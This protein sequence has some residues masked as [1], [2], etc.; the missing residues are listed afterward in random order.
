MNTIYPFEPYRD[1]GPRYA[2]TRVFS[3]YI[4]M[5]DGVRIA[6]DVYLPAGIPSGERIPTIL[7]QTR[8]WRSISLRAPFRW[9]SSGEGDS[10]AVTRKGK[11]FF[12]RRGYALVIADVRGTGASFGVS[13]HP[14]EAVTVQ[15]ASQIL[16]WIAAQPWSNGMVAGIGVS[17]LGTTAELLLA[18]AHPALRAVIP[19]FNHPDSFLDIGMPG[20][21]LNERF[22][23]AWAKLNDA[24]DLNRPSV[25]FGRAANMVIEGVSPVGGRSGLVE[26]REAIKMRPENATVADLEY[27]A[28]CTFRDQAHPVKGYTMDDQVVMRDSAR[29]PESARFR[30]PILASKV[31]VYGWAS[32]MDAGTGNAALRRFLTLSGPQQV[33]I[34]A[35]NHGGANQ[36]SPYQQGKV[37]LAPPREVQQLEILR[38]LDCALKDFPAAESEYPV[39]YYT[40]G[41]EQW[42]SSPTWPPPGVQME[43]WYLGPNHSLL[44][45]C[46]VDTTQDEY[47]VDYRASTGKYNRWW[48]LGV[49]E[50]QPVQYGDRAAQKPFLLGFE[51]APLDRDIEI[52]GTPVITLHVAS[53]EPDGAF[54][55][56]LEDVF[57][58]GRI[59]YLT[60]GE[61]RAINRKVAPK[62]QSP[63]RLLEP[64]HTFRAADALPLVPGEVAEITFGLLPISALIRR[65]HRLRVSLAGHDEGTFPRTPAQGNPVWTVMLGGTYASSIE[66]PVK[67]DRVG[68]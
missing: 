21:L 29:L 53:T 39:H 17:Y 57:P 7:H 51:S 56:Y 8:Y 9:L 16:D 20:G 64:F 59:V 68:W 15:D 34:G 49:A 27:L 50:R 55:V 3:V 32:W 31:P 22:I 38:F 28:R 24:L 65:G 40:I 35:W 11:D 2:R 45:E 14:W 61:L 67:R 41:A 33:T 60:E 62:G 23:R 12:V 36:S 42:Q 18:T 37:P 30:D 44:P 19:Q 6:A 5:R 43:R 46:P 58:D 47:A 26:L 66:L 4:P 54:I 13:H 1:P 52:S 25:A 48:E 10:I 63:Y